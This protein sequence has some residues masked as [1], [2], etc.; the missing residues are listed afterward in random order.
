M[1]QQVNIRGG[2]AIMSICIDARM[3]NHSGIGTYIRTLLSLAQSMDLSTI[4]PDGFQE[5][6][7]KDLKSVFSQASIYSLYEQIDIY[8]KLYKTRNLLFHAPHYNIPLLYKDK[9]L[10]TVHDLIHLKFPQ[11]LP[12]KAALAYSKFMLNQAGKRAEKI[13]AVSQNTKNDLMDMLNIPEEK[14]QVIYNGLAEYKVHDIDKSTASKSLR[15]LGVSKR[16][17]LYVGNVRPHKN[18]DRLIAAFSIVHRNLNDVELVITGAAKGKI[19][20]KVVNG[21]VFTGFVN[22]EDLNCL[23][24][25]AEIFVFPSLYEGFGFPPLEA[26]QRGIPVVCSNSSSLPEVVG[27]AALLFDPYEAEDIAD[28][29][30]KALTDTSLSAILRDKGREQVRKF[31]MKQFQKNMTD[32]YRS[33]I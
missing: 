8:R 19:E 28:K 6:G 29:I 15:K 10:V 17:L 5:E 11:L 2:E 18:I 23:Y 13:I 21:I 16:Y 9:M 24:S 3:I 25:N 22:N 12:N 27:D 33:M 32:L 1:P 30:M 4:L 20:D 26:M 7:Y 31:S 14:I